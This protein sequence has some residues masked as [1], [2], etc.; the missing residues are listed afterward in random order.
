MYLPLLGV[1]PDWE[2][3]QDGC[4][5]KKRQNLLS[6]LQ[7]EHSAALNRLGFVNNI[8]EGPDL[9]LLL[10]LQIWGMVRRNFLS[11]RRVVCLLRR[12]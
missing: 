7:T 2:L 4:K 10:K 11:N 1:H 3:A 8:V 6:F 12:G 9:H 5:M